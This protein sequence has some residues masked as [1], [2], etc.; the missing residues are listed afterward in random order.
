MT[1]LLLVVVVGSSIWMGID[2]SGRDFSANRFA[3]A[4]WKWVVGGLGLWV[5]AF[6]VYLVHR[7]RAPRKGTGPA[8]PKVTLSEDPAAGRS[9]PP[10][11]TR[12]P[13]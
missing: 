5:V 3:D 9:V 1:A 6:P 8:E 13:C 4:S 11:S 12:P 2:A 10:P 7:N